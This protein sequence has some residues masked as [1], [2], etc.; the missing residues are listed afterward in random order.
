[1]GKLM[2]FLEYDR[3]L[4]P[5]RD[6]LER[7]NDWEEIHEELPLET[8]KEQAARCMYCGVPFCQSGITLKGVPTGCPIRNLIPEWND[9]LY[10]EEWDEALNR[11]Q[12]TISFPEFTGRVCPAP[13]E[14]ACTC[15]IHQPMVTIRQNELTIIEHAFA[16]GHMQPRPPKT[17][18]GKTV[19]VVG[20]GPAGLAAAMR[21][22]RYGHTVTVFERSDRI[23]GLLMYG[24][25]N[26]KLDK[27]VIDRRV[28]L[29]RAEGVS[30]VTGAHVGAEQPAD[31]LLQEYDAVVLA[32]GS[33][34][35]RD[36]AVPGRE[37]QGV[38]FAVDY[39]TLATRHL[40][41]TSVAVPA[42]MDARGKHVI[43]IGG[44]DT[45]TDCV[46]TALRQGCRT[47]HQLEIM[48]RPSEERADSNPWPEYPRTLKTD[49][50]QVEAIAK[51]GEDP[52][53]YLTNARAVERDAQGKIAAVITEKIA[54]V[55]GEDG[56]MRME[57][58]PGSERHWPA[59]MVLIAM[60]FVGPE[61]TLAEAY[62]LAR[63][64]RSNIAA[65]QYQTSKP[66]V[67]VAGDMHSGQSLVVR[68]MNEGQEAAAACHQYLTQQ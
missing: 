46:G 31:A 60:G 68:A 6:P 38:L 1:M 26:M 35:P 2:G 30:F 47:V 37:G 9:L 65:E 18:S 54:W 66:G 22:N 45:G 25:P 55:K 14:G 13:C 3:C 23:G 15:G 4:P 12:R 50:G 62:G 49:Y 24:I 63:D 17:R 44:G 53:H 20:S 57:S 67:F 56:R 8:Q 48:P 40:L 27:K 36:L 16:A 58:V 21:L 59:D 28:N 19:A 42:E 7:I 34:K 39:L 61:D 11:L 33:G 41:D 52:R 64:A 29:M 5:D 32:C 10:H 51:F 43:I